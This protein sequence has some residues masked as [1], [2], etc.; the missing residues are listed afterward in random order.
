MKFLNHKELKIDTIEENFQTK[1]LEIDEIQL[2]NLAQIRSITNEMDFLV[3]IE[4]NQPFLLKIKTKKKP[5]EEEKLLL[6]NL[7]LYA[8][9]KSD[10][11]IESR[12]EARL[13]T[14]EAIK[15]NKCADYP[16]KKLINSTPHHN[17][18]QVEINDKERLF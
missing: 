4:S 5:G 15:N 14:P 8:N 16:L 12:V 1:V 3:N 17:L 13:T 2:G 10:D 7:S 18:Y 11:L 9:V 6:Y